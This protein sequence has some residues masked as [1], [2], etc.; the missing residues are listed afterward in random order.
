[1]RIEAACHE[2]K[3]NGSSVTQAAYNCGFNDLSYFS[4]VFKL[5]KGISPKD[6][7]K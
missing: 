1:M 3:V 6:Y 2:M 5:Y 4:K 7:K